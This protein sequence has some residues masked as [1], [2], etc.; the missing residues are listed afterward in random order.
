MSLQ[1]ERNNQKIPHMNL[2]VKMYVPSSAVV[3]LQ[4]AYIEQVRA[5]QILG[6]LVYWPHYLRQPHHS[7]KLYYSLIST[8]LIIPAIHP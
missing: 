7:T 3:V 4:G 6:W 8:A 2:H 5:S 1:E